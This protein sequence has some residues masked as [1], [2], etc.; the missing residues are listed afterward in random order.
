M[1]VNP[2]IRSFPAKHHGLVFTV[3]NAGAELFSLPVESFPEPLRTRHGGAGNS[4]L[5]Y[6]GRH[7]PQ[8]GEPAVSGVHAHEIHQ[9]QIA[10][11]LLVAADSFIVVDKVAAAIDDRF[12]PVDFDSLHVV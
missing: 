3:L 9:S 7:E 10:A 11:K 6:L 2:N 12:S 4:E 5:S 8:G 1:N